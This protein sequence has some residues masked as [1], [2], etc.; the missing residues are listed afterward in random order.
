MAKKTGKRSF[1]LYHA[2]RKPLEKLNDE[3]RGQLFLAILNYS[4]FGTEP[5]FEDSSVDIAFEFIRDA[6]DKDTAA[7]EEKSQRRAEAGS[8]GG[9]QKVA[10]LANA[11]FAKQ[12][13]ANQAVS[14]SAS[15][16]VSDIK[17]NIKKK[18]QFVPPTLEEVKAYVAERNSP[19]DPVAFWEYFEAGQW[20]DSEG[21]PVLAWKQKLLTW[22]KHQTTGRQ[23]QQ[24]PS[25]ITAKHNSGGPIDLSDLMSLVK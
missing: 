15:V 17:E 6:L 14:V 16:S 18:K 24:K 19:V 23:Y 22:E 5:D 10:N 13:V 8:K 9:K 11:T 21:K 1:V 12:N 3:Q 7:W 4:E 2:I 25:Q 20:K